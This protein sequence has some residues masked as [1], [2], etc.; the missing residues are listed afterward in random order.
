M[1]KFKKGDLVYIHWSFFQRGEYIDDN[2]DLQVQMCGMMKHIKI[3]IQENLIFSHRN[4]ILNYFLN[5]NFDSTVKLFDW[6]VKP[7]LEYLKQEEL[8]TVNC[9]IEKDPLLLN[10][11]ELKDGSVIKL[12]NEITF[13][14]EETPLYFKK[15]LESRGWRNEECCHYTNGIQEELSTIIENKIK[16]YYSFPK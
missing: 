12:N 3:Y 15:Y 5:F 2:M 1:N 10:G 13:G 9:F 11:V 6:L 14:Y 4:T 16:K 8:R 7:I